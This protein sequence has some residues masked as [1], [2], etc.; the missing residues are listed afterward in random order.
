VNFAAGVDH[1]GRNV[2]LLPVLSALVEGKEVADVA[3][4]CRL[5]ER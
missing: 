5:E 4:E 1:P 3:R 2:R